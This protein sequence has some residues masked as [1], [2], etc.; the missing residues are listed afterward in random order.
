MFL[1]VFNMKL[2]AENTRVEYWLNSIKARAPK[3]PVF[4]VG[5][6]LDEVGQEAA[7]EQMDAILAKYKKP[8]RLKGA[9]AVSC[10]TLKNVPELI[11]DMA[12]SALKEP[13]M[14]GHVPTS[15]FVLEERCLVERNKLEKTNE[16]PLLDWDVLRS[17]AVNSRILTMEPTT[18]E[19]TDKADLDLRRAVDVL[20]LLGTVVYFPDAGAGSFSMF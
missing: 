9:V 5:T 13:Y 1:V 15:Y 16:P 3:A 2:G 19:E 4:V 18:Q 7:Q 6:Y 17:M 12:T 14:G 11:G 10:A 8:F 20:H